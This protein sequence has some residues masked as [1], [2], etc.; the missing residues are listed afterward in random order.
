MNRQH[1]Q[2]LA[3]AAKHSASIRPSEYVATRR[4]RCREYWQA[5][6]RHARGSDPG[7]RTHA[8]LF[9]VVQQ[10]LA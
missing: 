9:G 3:E 5:S 4:A 10:V 7:Q 6:K 2:E 8:Q 1:S